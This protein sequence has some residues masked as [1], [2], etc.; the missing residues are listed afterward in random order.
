MNSSANWTAAAWG[1]DLSLAPSPLARVADHLEDV[2]RGPRRVP[3]VD[4]DAQDRLAPVLS[5]DG[6]GAG[7][8][9]VAAA[10]PEPGSLV[11]VAV[12]LLGIFSLRV[13]RVTG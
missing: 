4:P 11:L 3:G 7:Y 2:V 9:R 10:V 6:G 8:L 12:A 5:P 1:A 13:G